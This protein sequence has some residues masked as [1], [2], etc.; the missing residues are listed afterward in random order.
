MRTVELQEIGE[1]IRKIRKRRGLRLEDLADDNIS[2]AT[3]SNIERSVPHVSMEK[4]LYLLDKLNIETSQI[5][6][7]LTQEEKEMR[8]IQL[9]LET[10]ESL[11]KLKRYEKAVN[12]I[13]DLDLDDAHPFAATA[14]YLKGKCLIDKGKTKQAERSL[15]N[16]IK[17]ANQNPY[18]N[19]TNVEAA[20]FC[21]LAIIA[22]VQNDLDGALQFV[23]S[24]WGAFQKDGDRQY[25]RFIIHVNKAI[26]L[27]KLGRI[28]EGMRVIEAIWDSLYE[29]DEVETLLTFY[30]LRNE[31]MRRTGAFEDAVEYIHKGLPLAVR[32]NQYKFI[33]EFWTQ[34]G[35]IY[36]SLDEKEK[37][38]S[39]FDT[40]LNVNELLPDPKV[41]STTYTKLGTLYMQQNKLAE[42][43]ETINQAINISD[44]YNDVPRLTYALM[45]MGDLLKNR[46][47]DQDAITYYQRSLE[48][49]Q[50]HHLKYREYKL[51]L[52][53]AQCWHQLNEQEFQKCIRNMYEV[54]VELINKEG[55]IFEEQD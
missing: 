22:Y 33:F 1:I 35:C 24:A 48:L 50:K 42:A 17:L 19:S 26:Y 45:L 12:K 25:I 43:K 31:F 23:N 21:E 51:L 55:D 5:P 52:K 38:E 40:A 4:A 20:S 10:V 39:C 9:E 2:V 53:L 13:E 29:I 37:A 7:L 46:K 27:E 41:A 16:A 34:L 14:A 49:S 30:W 11:W 44:K 47:E 6:Y 36:T 15:Y 54:K 3:I 18:N 8:R 32:N 28:N